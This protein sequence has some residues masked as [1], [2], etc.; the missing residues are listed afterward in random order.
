MACV[1]WDARIN[2]FAA[3]CRIPSGKILSTLGGRAFCYAAPKLW[4]ICPVKYLAL[5]HS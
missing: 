1:P 4:T 2:Q 3:I 5:T